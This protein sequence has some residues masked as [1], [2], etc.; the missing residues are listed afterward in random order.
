VRQME[1]VGVCARTELTS[2]W[3]QLHQVVPCFS[4]T[5]FR[6][7]VCQWKNAAIKIKAKDLHMYL[8]FRAN[9]MDG[10]I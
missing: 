10:W 2:L 3:A 9:G 4:A 6:Y 7:D 1:R 8:G 5:H